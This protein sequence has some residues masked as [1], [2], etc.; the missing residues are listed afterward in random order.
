[1]DRGFYLT[2]QAM[3]RQLAAM[4]G[5]YYPL[6]LI[7][8]S[9]R[10]PFPG[11]RVFSAVQLT[12]DALVRF[13]RLRNWEGYDVFV[14]P[15]AGNRNAGYILLDL[16]RADDPIIS[17]MRA[18][19]HEPSVVLCTSPGH[20]QAWVRVRPT[21]L[22]AVAA[23]SI[24]RHLAARYGADRASADGRHC[25]R[26]AGCTN[27]KP[28]RRPPGGSA[29]WVRLLYAQAGL[30]TA[31]VSD[32]APWPLPPVGPPLP[33]P[34][35]PS[36]A[37]PDSSR[38]PAGATRVYSR[39]RHRRHIPQRFSPVDWSIADLWIAPRLLGCRVPAPQLRDV[40]RLGSP[41]FP[42]GPA[43]PED[44]LHRTLTRAAQTQAAPFPARRSPAGSH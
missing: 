14:L 37:L 40:L 19:G 39:W 9:T 15:F 8:G 10:K 34:S 26:L 7:H 23:T 13:L 42:R 4:P 24:A 35:G 30:A 16:D 28:T 43:D 32:Q 2:L 29:P 41:G 18:H 5:D 11:E 27:Q 44:Y 3:R 31:A 17:A 20:R 6:R 21:P 22:Q 1:M 12:R 33:T 38:T 36:T 25:R